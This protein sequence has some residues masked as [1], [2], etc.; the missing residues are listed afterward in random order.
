M[1][2]QPVA[3]SYR[4]HPIDDA[5]DAIVIGSGMGG[6]TA[7]AV[8]A[9]HAGKRVL[10]L[11][12]HYEPGG[13]T[14]VFHRPGYEWDV[15]VHYVGEVHDPRSDL[16]RIFDSL[17]SGGL[18][19][20]RMPDVYDRVRIGEREYEFVSGRERFR[21]RMKRYFPGE[22]S[23]VERYLDA[24]DEAERASL[25]Y[26]AEKAVPAPIARVGGA[27]MRRGFLRYA[28]RTTGEVLAGLGA[29]PELTAC[30]TAQW[31]DY[32]L[33]PAQSSFGIHAII[34]AHYLDGASYPL[35][36]ASRIAAAFAPAIH[37]AGGRI[38][39]SAEVAGVVL[40]RRQR[41]AGVRMA[42]GCEFRAPV[43]VSDAGAANTF[44]RLLPVEAPGVEAILSELSSVGPSMAHLCLYVG[45]RGSSASLGLPAANLWVHATPD[46]D[47]G[48]ARLASDPHAPFSS[49]FISSPSAKDPLFEE[50]HPGHSTMEVVTPAPWGWFEKWN[51]TGWKRRGAGYDE[52]KREMTGRLAAELVRHVP[53][54][55]GQIDYTE[56]STPLTTRHFAN[57][58]HGEIYGLA[59]TP[60]RFRMRGLRAA[61]PVHGLYL[62]GADLVAPGVGGALFGGVTAASAI[63]GRNMIRAIAGREPAVPAGTR[64]A[65]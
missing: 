6:L 52:W 22:A 11:E 27:W 62:T 29:S 58:F 3:I 43:V 44:G 19:W 53:A 1:N 37:D 5:W 39:T 35:G 17:T 42:D 46:H 50:R 57:H 10:V 63:L 61:T 48:V 24:V 54:A 26:F 47:A 32:G 9:R 31:G 45:L 36:G 20:R 12:R 21:D 8:L 2:Q 16:R 15:G 33:P 13:F 59:A 28:S 55:D 51:E 34:V 18:E 60:A 41:V 25:N 4:Q 56:L 64:A 38:V 23:T 65:A 7:A 49:L 14:H 40:D 30:L